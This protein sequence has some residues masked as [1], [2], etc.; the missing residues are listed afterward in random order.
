MTSTSAAT[1]RR[2][3]RIDQLEEICMAT[4]RI[5]EALH[6]DDAAR[7]RISPATVRAVEEAPASSMAS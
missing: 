2:D 4:A 3:A 7:S 6:N 1:A 5:I